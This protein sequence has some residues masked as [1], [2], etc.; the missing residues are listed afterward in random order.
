MLG[1]TNYNKVVHPCQ[2][3]SIPPYQRKVT[4]GSPLGTQWNY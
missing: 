2:Q 4:G 3:K 1:T